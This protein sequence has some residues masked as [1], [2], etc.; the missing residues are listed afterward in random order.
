MAKSKETFN[1][2]EKEKKRLK[3]RQDKAE[4]MEERKANAQKG[5]S[6]ED[7]MAYIDEDGNIS[8]TP[9]DPRKMKTFRQEDMQIA[10][11]RQEE[12]DQEEVTRKGVVAFFN[13]AKGFG[14]IND[15]Q[16]GERVFV[17]INQLAEPI[18]EG[19]KVTFEAETGPRGLSALNVKK[20]P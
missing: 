4:K 7:M 12:V 10:V 19:D 8:S 9:P 5:K 16:T 3:Q 2:K 14:F 20:N 1:K 17:H 11:P 13:E 15:T 6:L 18:Q